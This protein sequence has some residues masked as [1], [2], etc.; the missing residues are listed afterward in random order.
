M[1][2]VLEAV[3]PIEDYL[4]MTDAEIQQAWPLLAR[5]NHVR[6]EGV[7]HILHNENPQA[8]VNAL[9][10]FFDADDGTG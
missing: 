4:V 3:R 2:A 1:S 9:R 8:V 10:N 5:P 7:S 6:L